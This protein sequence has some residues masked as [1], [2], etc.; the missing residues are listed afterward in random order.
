MSVLQ[1]FEPE[2]Q[3]KKLITK[4]SVYINIFRDNPST[5][6]MVRTLTVLMSVSNIHFVVI[7]FE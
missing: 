7:Y 2:L 3:H 1:Q 4:C 5:S 6:T